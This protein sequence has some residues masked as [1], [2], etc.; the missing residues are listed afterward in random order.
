M[1]KRLFSLGL[2]DC[3]SSFE[4]PFVSILFYLEVSVIAAICLFLF[5][6]FKCMFRVFNCFRVELGVGATMSL[7][8][9]WSILGRVS[10][11]GRRIVQIVLFAVL[12]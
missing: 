3:G 2:T 7:R 9:D 12:K 5:E 6:F 10:Q 1:W 8:F 11:A 4:M